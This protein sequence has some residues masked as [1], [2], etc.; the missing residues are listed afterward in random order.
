MDKSCLTSSQMLGQC[1]NTQGDTQMHRFVSKSPSPTRMQTTE[2]MQ[3]RAHITNVCH[4]CIS[5]SLC[6]PTDSKHHYRDTL[7]HAPTRPCSLSVS[8][9]STDTLDTMFHGNTFSLF[10]RYAA[11]FCRITARLNGTNSKVDR[12]PITFEVSPP[13]VF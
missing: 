6:I 10:F 13:A 8:L 9:S 12:C 5:K 1:S 3:I 2:R 11:S 4:G 7:S